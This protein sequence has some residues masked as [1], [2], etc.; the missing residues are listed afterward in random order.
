MPT[1]D[2]Q[3]IPTITELNLFRDQVLKSKLTVIEKEIGESIGLQYIAISKGNEESLYSDNQVNGI[4]K[5]C[6]F[7]TFKDTRNIIYAAVRIE[8]NQNETGFSGFNLK[9]EI[10]QGIGSIKSYTLVYND[11]EF[12]AW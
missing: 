7:N 12:P 1:K 5:V 2:D 4:C 3:Y 6:F 10:K 9:G 11:N 8:G